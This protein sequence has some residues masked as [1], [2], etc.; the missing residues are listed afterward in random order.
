MT[1]KAEIQNRQATD[2]TTWA[3]DLVNPE[4]TANLANALAT[5]ATPGLTVLLEGPVGAGKS[6][7][8]R[9][10]IQSLM[11]QTGMIED[12]PSPTFTLVQTYE[13]DQLDVWHADLYRLTNPDELIELGLEQAFDTALCLIEWP[14]RLGDLR[15]A[16]AL[17]ISLTPDA[18]DPDRRFV[19]ING[20]SE[21]V[22][23]LIAAMETQ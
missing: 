5:Q 19:Q 9:C 3:S 8:A 20:P 6:Y 23:R 7:F 12:V 10:A 18:K 14:D 1:A 16:G 22:T 4:A 2:Q 21:I 15:P 13:L 17:N 11:A